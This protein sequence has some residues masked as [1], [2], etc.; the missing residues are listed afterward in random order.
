M[1]YDAS[2]DTQYGLTTVHHGYDAEEEAG[3]EGT[4][5][6]LL[7]HAPTAA[8]LTPDLFLEDPNLFAAPESAAGQATPDR[9]SS[10]ESMRALEYL[11]RQAEQDR[12]GQMG[13]GQRSGMALAD[14]QGIAGRR[15]VHDQAQAA[16]A[17]V[18]GGSG[19]GFQQQLAGLGDMNDSLL[20][21]YTAGY[22]ASQGQALD[23]LATLGEAATGLR[24]DT[25]GEAAARGSAIDA[26]NEHNLGYA[27][28]VH[29]RNVE[30]ETRHSRE[31]AGAQQQEYDNYEGVRR[32]GAG[33]AMARE[34]V[35]TQAEQ[36]QKDRD[37]APF[38]MTTGTI[39][40]IL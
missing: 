18:G 8:E 10:A 40:N 22:N 12:S 1:G 26:F 17:G 14:A 27:R 34:D 35:N 30:R 37:L 33:E 13:L 11:M 2:R 7:A 29:G 16:A 25:F 5:E 20:H 23:T 28:G 9:V 32:G 36:D 15:S 31:G 6:W 4:R 38:Y 3:H 24:G 21:N 39:R 19:A